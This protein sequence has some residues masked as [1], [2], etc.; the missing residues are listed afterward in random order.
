M[1]SVFAPLA[2][3]NRESILEKTKAVQQLA[4][5]QGKHI[6]RPKGLGAENLAKVR[7][8]LKKGLSVAQTVELTSTSLSSVKRYRNHLQAALT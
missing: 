6:G 2:E 3:Y 7:K 8:A 1:L 4:A 5:A